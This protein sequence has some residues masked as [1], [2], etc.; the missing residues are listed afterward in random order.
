[1]C[2][3]G[4]RM[5]K[6][7]LE[8]IHP[9]KGGKDTESDPHV[10]NDSSEAPAILSRAKAKKKKKKIVILMDWGIRRQSLRMPEKL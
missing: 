2:T 1:M 6:V 4:S 3:F 8:I 9:L 7:E 5:M 10:Y